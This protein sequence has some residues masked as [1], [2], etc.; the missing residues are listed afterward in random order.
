MVPAA[1]REAPRGVQLC[2][3]SAPQHSAALVGREGAELHLGPGVGTETPLRGDGVESG[4]GGGKERTGRGGDGTARQHVAFVQLVSCTGYGG[5]AM[6]LCLGL[7]WL[8][9]VLLLHFF[10]FKF[11]N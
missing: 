11:G 9:L 1:E 10:S 6:E 4:G 5:L 3:S 7:C 2:A 8:F